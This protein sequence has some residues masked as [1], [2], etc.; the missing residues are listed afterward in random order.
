M[1]QKTLS[2]LKIHQPIRSPKPLSALRK[3]CDLQPGEG[4]VSTYHQALAWVIKAL[5]QLDGGALSTA[6]AA[7]EGQRLPPLHLEVHPL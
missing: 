3:A 6:T 5:Q 2:M 1:Q 7:H 4:A